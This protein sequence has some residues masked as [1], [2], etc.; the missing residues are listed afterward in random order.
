MG[1]AQAG[2]GSRTGQ[3]TKLSKPRRS[4][5]IFAWSPI[6]LFFF[7]TFCEANAKFSLSVVSY[8]L[9]QVGECAGID[10]PSQFF[11]FEQ[12]LISKNVHLKHVIS[13]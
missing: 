4:F 9:Y 2:E 6:R 13:T 7:L 8:E 12:L 5:V 11:I 1:E 3:E 10:T